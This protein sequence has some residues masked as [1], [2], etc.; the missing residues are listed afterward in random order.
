MRTRILHLADLHLG[1]AVSSSLR[2]ADA[3]AARR[4]QEAR[5]GLLDRLADWVAR[6]D[7]GIAVVLLAGDVF[8]RHDPPDD[9]VARV[10]RALERIART[11]TVITVPGNHDELSYPKCVFRKRR[12]SWP[13]L[14][15]TE[16]EPAVVWQGCLDGG[17]R[18]EVISAAYEAGRATPGHQLDL[19][20]G[21]PEVLRVLL[22]H[23]TLIEHFSERVVE[24][25]RCFRIAHRQAAA[26]GYHYLALGHIHRFGCWRLEGTMAVY[27][28]PPIGRSL[29]DPGSNCL[30]TVQCAGS[31]VS[32]ER[33][34][35]PELLGVRWE[36]ERCRVAPGDRPQDV[37]EQAS[38]RWE[39]QQADPQ[40]PLT[41]IHGLQLEGNISGEDFAAQCARFLAARGHLALVDDRRTTP[42]PEFDIE[43]LAREAT[44][45]GQFVQQW[46]RWRE[47]EK[48]DDGSADLVLW[49]GL[50]A[51]VPSRR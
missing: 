36:V 5:D 38:A 18:L 17:T 39:A 25:E 47:E 11:A 8:D 10:C 1:A 9:L 14:L 26:A 4:L 13:G 41:I 3:E 46:K 48:P 42:V 6:D 16:P 44:L 43:S 40:P 2:E 23:G 28:G 29:D 34:D 27:P 19:P 31:G 24:G 7:S 21:S 50:T 49:E 51:L 12:Q 22:A 32:L 15:V 30:I 37:A 20:Q 45:A 35:R 33:L